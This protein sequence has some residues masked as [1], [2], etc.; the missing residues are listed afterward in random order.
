MTDLNAHLGVREKALDAAVRGWLED[1]LYFF[2][3]SIC[4]S[5][6]EADVRRY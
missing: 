2:N 1:R 6:N 5:K 3:V 4:L